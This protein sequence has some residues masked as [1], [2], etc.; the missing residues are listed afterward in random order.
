MYISANAPYP[1]GVLSNLTPY[2]F[3]V[4][5]VECASMEGFLQSLKFSDHEKQIEVCQ[6]SRHSAR[7]AAKDIYRKW[8]KER[9]YY[10]KEKEIDRF[11]KEYQKLLDKAYFQLS[12]NKE[13]QKALLATRGYHLTHS[14]GKNEKSKTSLTQDE[15][16]SRLLK[17]RRRLIFM[18]FLG[19]IN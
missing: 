6:L 18:K 15:F 4:E 5:G 16:C 11:G 14:I 10:W 8:K 7:I 9:K 19:I 3:K 12:K 17:I 1:A 13:F 2:L